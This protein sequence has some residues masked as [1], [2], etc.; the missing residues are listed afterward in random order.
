MEN[1]LIHNLAVFNL[2]YGLAFFMM[3]IIILCQPKRK[4]EFKLADILWLLVVFCLAQAT[5]R[6]LW[7]LAIVNNSSSLFRLIDAYLRIIAYFCLFE[8][9]L[10]LLIMSI[11]KPTPY[12]KNLSKLLSPWLAL[13]ICFIITLWIRLHPD[14][15][16]TYSIISRYFLSFPGS[17]LAG[18]GFLLYYNFHRRTFDDIKVR[19]YFL[20]AAVAFFS[21]A[22]VSGL[23]VPKGNLFLSGWLN[24]ESF[25]S[26]FKLPISLL[27]TTFAL[28]ITW[29]TCGI[30]G[31]FTWE[32]KRSNK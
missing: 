21:Y 15:Y 7:L 32:E 14:N 18:S 13:S 26:F 30:L 8:F 11:A 3:A 24:E 28:I 5:T 19:K 22:V 16:N 25:T 23:I 10:R 17:I 9:G 2:I 31:I 27:R 1:L 20:G 29:F 6:F 12:Y 4:S